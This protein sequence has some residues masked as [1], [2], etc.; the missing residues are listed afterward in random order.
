MSISKTQQGG[1]LVKNI[2]LW[3]VAKRAPEIFSWSKAGARGLSQLD[4]WR[5]LASDDFQA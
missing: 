1:L 3:M 5:G 4:D 2:H